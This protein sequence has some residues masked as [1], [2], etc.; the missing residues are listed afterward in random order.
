LSAPGEAWEL[1]VT[2]LGA[3][4]TG[5]LWT[6]FWRDYE[7]FTPARVAPGF[8]AAVPLIPPVLPGRV[9]AL[10]H[11]GLVYN[12][13]LAMAQF[14]NRDSV[15]HTYQLRLFYPGVA[16]AQYSSA[17]LGPIAPGDMGE[18]VLPPSVLG[19]GASVTVEQFEA[20][21]TTP[22]MAFAVYQDLP[23]TP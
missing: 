23:L 1:D 15:P 19:P 21:V 12:S 8:P 16:A 10:G 6:V 7:G 18:T 11:P 14:H 3:G 20:T 22:S 9:S 2:A 13:A 4:A 5:I 17:V